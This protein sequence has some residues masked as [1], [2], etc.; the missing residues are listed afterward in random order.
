MYQSIKI[1]GKNNIQQSISR[2]GN[3]LDNSAMK[4]I[5]G[6]LKTECYYGK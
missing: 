4:S 1:L 6:Q 5:F 2:K 3:S